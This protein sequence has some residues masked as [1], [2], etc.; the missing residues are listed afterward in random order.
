MCNI[1]TCTVFDSHKDHLFKTDITTLQGRI[2]K[3]AHINYSVKLYH[4]HTHKHTHT[5]AHTHTHTH[6]VSENILLQYVLSYFVS[7]MPFLYSHGYSNL[8]FKQGFQCCAII[9]TYWVYMCYI[10]TVCSACCS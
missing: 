6:T 1:S 4:T 5:R 3:H 9:T 7:V 10:R 2:A 8:L